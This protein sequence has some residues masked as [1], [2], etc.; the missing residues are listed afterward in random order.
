VANQHLDY[1]PTLKRNFSR[2]ETLAQDRRFTVWLAR[3]D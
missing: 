2:V 1:L 3:R